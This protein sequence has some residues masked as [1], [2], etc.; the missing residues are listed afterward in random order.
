[1]IPKS[2]LI[3]FKT[4]GTG[5]IIEAFKNPIKIHKQ[6]VV[7]LVLTAGHVVCDTTTFEPTSS[8]ISCFLDK[9]PVEAIFIQSFMK[10]FSHPMT[11]GSNGNSFVY[12]G[13]LALLLLICDK[14]LKSF[15]LEIANQFEIKTGMPV[16]AVGFPKPPEDPLYCCPALCDSTAEEINR[17]VNIAFNNFKSL[18]YSDGVIVALTENL[19][20][21]DCAGTNGMSGGPILRKLPDRNKLIGIY[22]GGPPLPGQYQ[23]FLINQRLRLEEYSE[24]FSSLVNLEN[25]ISKYYKNC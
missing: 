7:G 17:E 24:V 20:D 23:L 2:L 25:D 11:S 5:F 22:V 10:T 4:G 12:S 9:D 6:F 1:M 16:I 8:E 18:V 13:D 14:K 21:I 15:K 19:I 3:E